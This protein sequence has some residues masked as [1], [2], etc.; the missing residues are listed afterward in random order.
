M[1]A[2]REI[3]V[4]DIATIEKGFYALHDEWNRVTNGLSKYQVPAGFNGPM[5]KAARIINRL[6]SEKNVSP[7]L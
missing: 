4:K 1:S 6:A 2:E 3:S 5:I 7:E